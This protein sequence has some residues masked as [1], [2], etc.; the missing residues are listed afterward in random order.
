MAIDGATGCGGGD[1]E[2]SECKEYS[3]K[4]AEEHKA[5][6]EAI[7]VLKRQRITWKDTKERMVQAFSSF[8]IYLL[9]IS[10]VPA[11]F[12]MMVSFT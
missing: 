11:I 3:E 10:Y 12:C 9:S 6:I 5:D 4:Q 8:Q 2:D 1:S 7:H